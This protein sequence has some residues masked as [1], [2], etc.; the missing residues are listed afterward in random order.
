MTT[1]VLTHPALQRRSALRER[2]PHA[3]RRHTARVATRF[4]VLL[5]GDILAIFLARAVAMWLLAETSFGAESLVSTP[6]VN[7]GT[8]FLFLGVLTLVAV[9][10]TGGHSRHRA[11]N[12]P[13]RLFAAAAGVVLLSW[14]GGIARGYLSDLV[15]PMVATAGVVWLSLLVTRQVSEWFLQHVWPARRGAGAAILVGP[16]IAARRFEQAIAAPGGDYQVAGY[17][18]TDRAEGDDFLGTIDDLPTLIHEH[19]VEAV[20]VCADL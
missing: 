15:L 3:V 7:G 1:P 6:L 11:L 19:D 12:L 17:V 10:A 20:V 9:F 8:R 18:A 4:V 2:R 5:A 13:I 16:P 14:A